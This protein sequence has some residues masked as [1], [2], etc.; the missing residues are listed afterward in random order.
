MTNWQSLRLAGFRYKTSV[1]WLWIRLQDSLERR[2]CF[3]EAA[4]D[5]RLTPVNVCIL[6]YQE[7]PH[8]PQGLE[9]LYLTLRSLPSSS[10]P[11]RTHQTRGKRR[12]GSLARFPTLKVTSVRCAVRVATGAVT[13]RDCATNGRSRRNGGWHGKNIRC[14]IC[15]IW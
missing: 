9:L 5:S 6:L 8:G 7:G 11:Y 15:M 4:S 13:R 12:A 14:I 1:S 2:F 10:S 3:P